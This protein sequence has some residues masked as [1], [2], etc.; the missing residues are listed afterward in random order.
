MDMIELLTASVKNRASDLHISSGMPPLLRIDG[1]MHQINKSDSLKDNALSEKA[2]KDLIY[3]IMKEN[4]KARFEKDLECDFSFKIDNVARFRVNV[5]FQD[6]GI[7]AVFRTIPDK[8]LSLEDLKAPRILSELMS[9][10]KGLILITGPTGSGKSTTLAAM[11]DYYNKNFS[12]HILTIEDPI[13]FLHT[14]QRSLINQRELG[15]NTLSFSNALRAALREDPDVILV[16]ELRDLETI[17]LALTA[18]ET[19]H[20]VLATLHS[21]SANKTINRIIDAF[22]EG[23]K[24]MVRTMLAESL[25]AVVAQTLLKK[26]EGGRIA[27]HEILLGTNPV[28]NLI[29]ENKIPQIYST[30][31]SARKLGMITM[32]SA[33]EDLLKTN[34]ITRE[35][36]D[37]ALG[38][39]GTKEE[40][41]KDSF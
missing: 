23:D 6:R 35:T 12:G 26:K 25:E 28:K 27:V 19:G 37:Y 1:D 10:K 20:L 13:E 16:G 38:V 18:A 40:T 22:P 41:K 24:T 7:A 30:M 39:L 31:Q 36:H 3:S 34:M 32:E 29:R 8:I 33:L 15:V 5:F 14:S 11:V 17:K 9:K 2:T 21:S 4:Q